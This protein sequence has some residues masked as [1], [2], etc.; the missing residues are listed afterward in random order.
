MGM[1]DKI[2]EDLENNDADTLDHKIIANADV[3]KLIKD[4]LQNDL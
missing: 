2:I 4:K 3:T 1:F